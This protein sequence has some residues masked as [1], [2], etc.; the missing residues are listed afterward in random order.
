METN[1]FL[2]EMIEKIIASVPQFVMILTT[3][4]YALKNL[5]KVAKRFP[6]EISDTRKELNISFLETKEEINS[7]FGETK[8]ELV[9]TFS[10]TRKEINKI[11]S[12]VTKQIYMNVNKEMAG[13]KEELVDYKKELHNM[14]TQTNLLAR[15]NKAFMEI[16]SLVISKEPQKIRDGISSAV[17]KRLNMTKK[18][19]EKY[20]ER[21]MGE[22]YVLQESMKDA[23]LLLGKDKFSAMLKEIGYEEK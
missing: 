12:E 2:Q 19:L 11:V 22:I 3:L 23:V 9:E 20:P 16:I 21:I 1:A 8:K 15:E 6:D 17:S 14:Y 18:E 4:F 13:M 5:N 10:S 7:F